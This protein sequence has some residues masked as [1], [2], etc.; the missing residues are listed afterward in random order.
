MLKHQECLRARRRMR[1][2]FTKYSHL[3]LPPFP[4]LMRAEYP[5][6]GQGLGGRCCHRP[7]GQGELSPKGKF[8]AN[9]IVCLCLK[10]PCLCEP[11][12]ESGLVPEATSSP[13]PAAG[14]GG[15]GTG[16]G[17]WAGA[18]VPPASSLGPVLSAR[19]ADSF[20][21][22]HPVLP[23]HRSHTCPVP[24]GHAGSS[25][26]DMVHIG[27]FKTTGDLRGGTQHTDARRAGGASPWSASLP[28]GAR[29]R[30]ASPGTAGASGSAG[31][32]GSRGRF[33]ELAAGAAPVWIR[34]HREPRDPPPPGAVYS[35]ASSPLFLKTV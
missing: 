22:T 9:W 4:W 30:A 13:A 24:G 14:E 27:T 25:C 8:T 15:S 31:A 23:L 10:N 34:E 17:V 35:P 29:T 6:S 12:A 32:A 28:P 2:H 3:F 33:L 7:A 21:R 19:P 5:S 11:V 18:P 20:L 16:R 1:I 26:R